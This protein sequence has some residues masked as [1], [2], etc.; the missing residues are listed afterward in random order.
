VKNA[1][2]E[3]LKPSPSHLFG[4]PKLGL[5]PVDSQQKVQMII[6]LGEAPALNREN[7]DELPEPIFNPLLA[8]NVISA[9]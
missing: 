4:R 2:G 1:Q 7:P 3:E 6:H 5:P 8:M 9:A